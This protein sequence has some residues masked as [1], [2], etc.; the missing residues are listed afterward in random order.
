MD[1]SIPQCKPYKT[2]TTH[3]YNRTQGVEVAQGNYP[4]KENQSR[5][6]NQTQKG[7][8]REKV[9]WRMVQLLTLQTME[10]RRNWE[11]GDDELDASD[12]EE[13]LDGG[14]DGTAQG[15]LAPSPRSG[16][17]LVSFH[18]C[19]IYEVIHILMIIT[20]QVRMHKYIPL[21]LR[22]SIWSPESSVQ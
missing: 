22:N 19:Q 8:Y 9:R 11:V 4:K 2:S 10:S 15:A 16:A 12:L 5:E 7:R 20:I 17:H 14:N 3:N 13:K 6:S 1:A 18:L 21:Q